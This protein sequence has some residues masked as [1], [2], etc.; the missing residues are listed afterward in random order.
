MGG[1]CSPPPLFFLP[2]RVDLYLI[3]VKRGGAPDELIF[4]DWPL[5][6]DGLLWMVMVVVLIYIW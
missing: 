5:L 4:E 6:L 1:C 2:L 3:H